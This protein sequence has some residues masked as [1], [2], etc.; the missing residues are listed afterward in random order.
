MKRGNILSL[1][2]LLTLSAGCSGT[3]FVRPEE[4]L[5]VLGKTTASEVIKVMGNPSGDSPYVQDD[6]TMREI[7]YS[8]ASMFEKPHVPGVV[9]SRSVGFLFLND[10]M[11][12]QCFM[13]SFEIDH[14]DF[15]EDKVSQITK[16]KTTYEEMVALLGKPACEYIYP[17]I[18]HVSLRGA[19]YMYTQYTQSHHKFIK[20][21]I[22]EYSSDNV[23]RETEYSAS[24]EK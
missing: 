9:P 13:S 17:L 23:I 18:K 1:F 6:K 8:F 2:C 22:V 5:F 4:G 21:F 14:T 7:T 15:D 20:A 3:N 19:G 24:G 16:D 10:I 11:V 12:G